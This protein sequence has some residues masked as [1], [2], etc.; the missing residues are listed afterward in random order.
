MPGAISCR[1]VSTV[2]WNA[3]TPFSISQGSVLP[4]GVTTRVY[5]GFR[6]MAAF[7]G[8]PEVL[9]AATVEATVGPDVR[10]AIRNVRKLRFMVHLREYR[11]A[12]PAP[13][14]FSFVGSP[15]W[16]DPVP[17]SVAGRLPPMA[18][19]RSVRAIQ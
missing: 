4:L 7:T 13:R 19:S 3:L 1:Q 14:M 15:G 6:G 12:A 8:C 11:D 18:R 10:T 16:G 9:G 17:L 5:E 2:R